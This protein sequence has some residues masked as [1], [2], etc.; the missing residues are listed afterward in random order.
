MEPLRIP[1]IK[2]MCN[3]KSDENCVQL[4]LHR[5]PTPST[6]DLY[7]FK[8]YLFDHGYPEEFLLF[9]RNFNMNL[10]ATGTLDIDVNIQYM[11]TLFRGEAL[12]Q[13]DLL[14]ADV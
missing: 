3:G 11:C 4:K 6:L 14:S 1:L 12:R 10:T 9:V 5:D 2:W 8:K 7:E 13:I